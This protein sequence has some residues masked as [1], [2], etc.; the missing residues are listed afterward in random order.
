MAKGQV[1]LRNYGGS[2]I[3]ITLTIIQAIIGSSP[4]KSLFPSQPTE[5]IHAVIEVY[6]DDRFTELDR[7]LYDSAAIIRRTV[8]NRESSAEEVLVGTAQRSSNDH[9]GWMDA[10][11]DNWEFIFFRNA[12]G[13]EDVCVK[14]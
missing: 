4:S 1:M 11:D 10:H 14:A 3:D 2:M 12:S 9:S 5:S 7:T 13:A 6:V 8:T